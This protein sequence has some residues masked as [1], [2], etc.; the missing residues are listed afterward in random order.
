MEIYVPW[1]DIDKNKGHFAK[2]S[3]FLDLEFISQWKMAWTWST[4]HGPRAA[5][6]HS[7]PRIGPRWWLT[8]AQPSGRSRP[9]WLAWGWQRERGDATWSGD[10]SPELGWRWGGGAAAVGLRLQVAMAST[11][12]RKGGGE[13]KG[14][15]APPECRYPFIWSGRGGG[16]WDRRG[17]GGKWRPQWSHYQSEGGGNY[18]RLKRG[19]LL[20]GPDHWGLSMAQEEGSAAAMAWWCV[21]RRWRSAGVGHVGWKAEHVGG[22]AGLKSKENLF[23]E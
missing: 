1:V 21:G 11:R 10:R 19:V 23:S 12:E 20:R 15:G 16:G 5:P 4:A 18:N 7:G 6:V 22:A 8:G 2:W 13:E 17:S 14:W 3:G 9:R